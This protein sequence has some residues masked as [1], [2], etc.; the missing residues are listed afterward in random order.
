M[1][2]LVRDKELGALSPV[3]P[4]VTRS[5]LRQNP[6]CFEASV[7]LISKMGIATF[8]RGCPEEYRRAEGGRLS[9]QLDL[10][11]KIPGWGR[12]PGEGHGNPLQ[13]TCLENPLDRGAWQAT[14]HGISQSQTQLKQL[15]TLRASRCLYLTLIKEEPGGD[16]G[17][18]ASG[19]LEG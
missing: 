19:P 7:F 14:V 12:C 13:Y 6:C 3:D 10:Q 16:C 1:T 8:S 15:S 2:A 11:G 9:A 18:L 17:G 4:C 5:D